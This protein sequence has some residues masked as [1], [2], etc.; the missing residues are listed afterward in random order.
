MAAAVSD[1]KPATFIDQK[2]KKGDIEKTL[3]LA[4]NP[5]ILKWLGSRKK[6]SQILIGFAMETENLRENA[7]K[8]LR[9]KNLDWICANDL[10]EPDAGFDSE[11]NTLLL[12]SSNEEKRYSGSKTVVSSNILEEIFADS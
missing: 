1:F 3:E 2:Q 7:Q 10:N 6:E 4:E 8:K 12:I 9:K 11:S 5:D